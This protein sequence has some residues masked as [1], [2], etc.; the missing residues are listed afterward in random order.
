MPF[1]I[2]GNGKHRGL[3]G[4]TTQANALQFRTKEDAERHMLDAGIIG[5]SV[6]P[7][8]PQPTPGVDVQD[9]GASVF[10][11]KVPARG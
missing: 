2:S 11:Y 3:S 4:W 10:G 9:G 8:V 5:G 7:V 1:T 6:V